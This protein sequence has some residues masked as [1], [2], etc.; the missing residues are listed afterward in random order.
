MY[1]AKSN[2][3]VFKIGSYYL[4]WSMSVVPAV[5]IVLFGENVTIK[6]RSIASGMTTGTIGTTAMKNK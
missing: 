6:S 5:L 1:V 4:I 2:C 3:T